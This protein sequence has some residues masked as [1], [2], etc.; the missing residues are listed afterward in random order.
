MGVSKP[1]TND[2][3]DPERMKRYAENWERIFGKKKENKKK[4][5]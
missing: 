5:K 1:Y 4:K 3:A 2:M